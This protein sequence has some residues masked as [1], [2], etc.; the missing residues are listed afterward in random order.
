M[1]GIKVEHMTQ[2]DVLILL[3]S[4]GPKFSRTGSAKIGHRGHKLEDIK[5]L[6][7]NYI[8]WGFINFPAVSFIGRGFIE[9]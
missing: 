1:E 5:S 6:R 7:Y 4:S 3:S 9:S 8:E 2:R